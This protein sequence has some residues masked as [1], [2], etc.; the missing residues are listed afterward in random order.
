MDLTPAALSFLVLV[1]VWLILGSLLPML[2]L[3]IVNAV[4]EGIR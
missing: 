2:L 3:V 4:L 1:L